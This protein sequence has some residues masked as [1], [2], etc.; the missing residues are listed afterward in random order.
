[1]ATP[2]Q[3]HLTSEEKLF[4]LRSG[5]SFRKWS[6][7]DDRRVCA[8]CGKS[9]TG[10]QIE[11]TVGRQGQLRL[12]C[13]TA[14]CTAGPHEWVYPGDPLTSAKARRDWSRIFNEE[15]ELEPGTVGQ[16]LEVSQARP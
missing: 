13:P 7:L 12:G 14:D 10:R 9:I 6:S 4:A 1:M 15:P 2:R 3:A 11:I 5:D 16:F 8:L